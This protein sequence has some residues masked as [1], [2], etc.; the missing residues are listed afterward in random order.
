MSR[1]QATAGEAIEQRE[2]KANAQRTRCKEQKGLKTHGRCPWTRLK[3]SRRREE[4]WM[5][6]G[7]GGCVRKAFET[8]VNKSGTRLL[9]I[10]SKLCK[11]SKC[12]LSCGHYH[13]SCS[14]VCR[15]YYK[16]FSLVPNA[17]INISS[18]KL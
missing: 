14:R 18:Q 12:K 17:I 1:D 3:I 9:F 11:P 8:L 15:N 5:R 6:Q 2:Q 13:G 16:G 10:N 4:D 7:I